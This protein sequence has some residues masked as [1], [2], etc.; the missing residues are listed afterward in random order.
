[1]R[2]C[3]SCGRENPDDANSCIGCGQALEMGR[4][5]AGVRKTVT[6]LFCDVVDSTS[7][8]ETLDPESLRKA[9]DRF[10]DAMRPQIERHGGIVE[11]FIG[12]AVMAVFGVPVVHEDDPLRAVRSAAN[13]RDALLELNKD[14][15]RDHGVTLASRIGVTT[16]EV[17]ASDV[18]SGERIVTG[19][20]VSTAAR[21]EQAA[22]PNEILV[23]EPTYRLVR[24]AV[25]AEAVEP[26]RA[27]GK[28]QPVRAWRVN[29]VAKSAAS[30]SRPRDTPIVG[31]EHELR[32]L[33]GALDRAQ[34]ERAC[35][36]VTVLGP[37]GVGKSRLV[38]EFISTEA[39]LSTV[40]RGRCLSYGDGITFW[41][42]IE[43]LTSA[44]TLTGLEKPEVAN[45][46]LRGLLGDV[47]EAEVIAD[48]LG[49]VLGVAGSEAVPE[50]T[51]WAVRKMF[52]ALAREVPIVVDIDDLHWAEPTLLDLIEHIVDWS[53]DAP[54]LLLCSARSDLI[55]DRPAW[56]RDRTN[57]A[58]ISVE[59]LGPEEAA[60]VV[61][62]LLD[63]SV[64]PPS[65]LERIEA[66]AEGNPL[67][68]EQ[69]GDADR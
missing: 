13:M 9:M 6:V 19:D 61:R 41:P 52:Q 54:I 49:H 8:G 37:P 3:S 27:K 5:F 47:P 62:N 31:R 1:V 43:M 22:A 40:L 39:A 48:R 14:L 17:V 23:G 58:S 7:I 16:G 20:A 66:S 56:A 36:L 65:A 51:F 44:A 69:T 57:T 32:L 45:A 24:D 25:E 34:R 38:D 33:S 15:E 68:L 63:G 42:L 21:L 26:V 12:D 55:E 29:V 11:K 46:K 2:I 64:L 10:F 35:I 4:R 30:L 59:P 60:Q 67:F 53:R 28:R 50:E 18:A